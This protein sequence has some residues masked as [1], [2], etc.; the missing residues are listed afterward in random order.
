MTEGGAYRMPA[1][2]G[3]GGLYRTFAGA[4]LGARVSMLETLDEFWM[5]DVPDLDEALRLDPNIRM[6][7]RMHPD[8]AAAIPNMPG[9]ARMRGKEGG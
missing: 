1:D 2:S 4:Q 5:N 3:M 9:L 7:L 6:K 8:V